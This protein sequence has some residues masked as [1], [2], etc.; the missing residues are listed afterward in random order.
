MGFQ[1]AIDGARGALV[2]GFDD[3]PVAVHAASRKR[4]LSAL[5]II[6]EPRKRTDSTRD[7][8]MDIY[9]TEFQRSERARLHASLERLRL[10][11]GLGEA[12]EGLRRH[13]VRSGF[14]Q[15]DLSEVQRFEFERRDGSG[16]YLA[17]QYNPARARRFAG[18]GLREPPPRP[19]L[20]PCRSR[21]RR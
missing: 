4:A 19:P 18:S 8:G 5:R 3:D 15:D 14:I 20:S 13:Q 6:L 9:S 7:I 1:P 2:V 17:A 11:V 10:D 12:L 21:S 16:D